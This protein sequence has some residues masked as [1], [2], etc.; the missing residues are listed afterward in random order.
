MNYFVLMY[1]LDSKVWKIK[2][3]VNEID[4][5]A[6]IKLHFSSTMLKI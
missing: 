6:V 5:Q 3:Y 1:W 4:A 2:K